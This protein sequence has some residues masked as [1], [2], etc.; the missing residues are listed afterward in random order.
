MSPLQEKLTS[1]RET[2][3]APVEAGAMVG[4]GDSCRAP[5]SPA[6]PAALSPRWSCR[7]LATEA[8]FSSH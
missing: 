5:G 7:L 3:L 8:T 2:G 6:A 1:T 4:R